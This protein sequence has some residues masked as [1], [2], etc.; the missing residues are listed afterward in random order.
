LKHDHCVA[1]GTPENLCQHHL[2]PRSLGGSDV[3]S[4]LLTLCGSCHAKAHQVQANWRQGELTKAALQAK[5]VRGERVGQI[6]FGYRCDDGINLNPD[7]EEQGTITQV[8]QFKIAGLSL[9]AIA[10]RLTATNRPTRGAA[11]HPQTIKNILSTA[12]RINASPRAIE[13]NYKR[14]DTLRE[15][16]V[17]GIKVIE[18][19]LEK[20]RRP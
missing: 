19:E 18:A 13:R 5:K 9:R 16:V 10:A 11:W 7:A 1:C 17:R 12:A 15:C 3:E 14:T 2:V 4:N 20:G 6:P 8:Q